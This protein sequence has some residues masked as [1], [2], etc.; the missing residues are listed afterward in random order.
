MIRFVVTAI[1]MAAT[2]F[3]YRRAHQRDEAVQ[4]RVECINANRR[5]RFQIVDVCTGLKRRDRS[6]VRR[7]ERDCLDPLYADEADASS[8]F[9]NFEIFMILLFSFMK[10]PFDNG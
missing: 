6:V 2:V 9:T 4:L 3:V 1:P 5:Q 10:L 8:N 7:H